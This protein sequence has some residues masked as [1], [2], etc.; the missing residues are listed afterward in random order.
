MSETHTASTN[1]GFIARCSRLSGIRDEQLFVRLHTDLCN[2]SIFLLPKVQ[3]K[4]KLTKARPSIYLMKKNPDSKTTFIFLGA[5]LVVRRVRL[6]PIILSAHERALN[7]RAF[8][9]YNIT[10]V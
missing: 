6:N 9:R 5:Y 2:V 7:K 4:I 8:A 3:L 10:R 1:V